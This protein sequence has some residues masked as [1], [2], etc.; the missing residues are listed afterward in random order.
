MKTIC[1][2]L[3]AAMM[4]SLVGS[5]ALAQVTAIP[6]QENFNDLPLRPPVDEDPIGSFPNAF[7]HEPPENWFNQRSMVPGIGNPIVGVEEWEGWSFA[8]KNFWIDVSQD[9]G[10]SLFTRGQ[11]VVAVADPDEWNDLGDPANTI[12]FYNTIL[13]TPFFD[14]G[15][16]LSK[17]SRL[18]L[19]FDSS[20]RPGPP[21]QQCC[22]DGEGFD[23]NGNNQKVR[24]VARYE[25]G[26]QSE[27]L[28][29]DAAPF[30]NPLNDRPSLDPADDPNP[31]F[32]SANFNELVYVDLTEL[33]VTT[34]N[35]FQILFGMEDAGDD[36][37][38]AFD[39]MQM[40]SLDVVPGDMDLSGFVDTDDIADFAQA[41]HNPLD[42]V[43]THF[44]E[45]PATRGSADNDFNF[46]DIDWFVN[47]LNGGGVA[48]SRDTIV[49]AIQ[50][51]SVPE[52]STACLAALVFG[53]AL[54]QSRGRR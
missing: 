26:T 18:Q 41:I 4:L 1:H 5:S 23:P 15:E 53:V 39:N 30:I 43:L 50:A 33:L 21:Q 54:V 36:G 6:F 28:R 10:R 20:W 31:F 2:A 40:I 7:T 45:S 24:I 22:D 37:W 25:D 27:L 11:G 46:D 42:Y 29:W 19:K 14:I 17:G 47:I 3:L 13:E 16:L 9:E 52:P 38:F 48:A 51:Q 8:N 35:R 32:K 34:Q 49:A 44:G 12:G